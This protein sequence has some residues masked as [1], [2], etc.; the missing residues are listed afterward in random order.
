[1]ISRE[2]AAHLAALARTI[3]PEWDQLATINTVA[4]LKDKPLIAVARAVIT[5]AQN[6]D[7]RTPRAI[8]WQDPAP[9]AE[10]TTSSPRAGE[11]C[12]RDGH[13]GWANNCAQC[14]S[15]RIAIN[16]N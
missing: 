6:P 14:R 3:R 5:A 16:S 12:N 2:Q 4:E 15:E 10:I 9:P 7:A 1:M 11:I 8:L 13:S